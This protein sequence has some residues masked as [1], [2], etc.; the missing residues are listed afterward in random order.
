MELPF[1]KLEKTMGSTGWGGSDGGAC[2]GI[3]LGNLL[4][5]Q[6]KK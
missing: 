2:F 5:I 6:V 3:N 1:A 4:H